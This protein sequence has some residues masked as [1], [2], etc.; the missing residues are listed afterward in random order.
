MELADQ[1]D[2]DFFIQTKILKWKEVER[3][4]RM[5]DPLFAHEFHRLRSTI[6]PEIKESAKKEQFNDRVGQKERLLALF[7]IQNGKLSARD[8]F[9]YDDYHHYFAKVKKEPDLNQWTE[10][11]RYVLSRFISDTLALKEMMEKS[12]TTIK[13]RNLNILRDHF[14]PMIRYP[15]RA[16]SFELPSLEEIKAILYA[17]DVGYKNEGEKLFIRRHYK[18]PMLLFPKETFTTTL[19]ADEARLAEVMSNEK[20]LE[21]AMTGARLDATSITELRKQLKTYSPGMSAP[22]SNYGMYI[23]YVYVYIYIYMYIRIYANTYIFIYLYI[24]IYI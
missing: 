18:L 10:E 12:P 15:D 6:F 16:E 22:S 8:P 14:F 9:Y 19:L 3:E 11:D 2:I 5:K 23:E 1:G 13:Q 24:Y 7:N 17:N 20:S 21:N 4:R